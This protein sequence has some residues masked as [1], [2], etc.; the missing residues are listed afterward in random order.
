MEY[1]TRGENVNRQEASRVLR[2]VVNGCEG[3]FDLNF[4]SI[5]DSTAQ[6]RMKSTGYEIYVKCAPNDKIRECLP[7]ILAKHQLKMA[8]LEDAIIIYKPK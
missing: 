5:T 3:G 7:P 4:V 1:S 2:E 6:I 8:E